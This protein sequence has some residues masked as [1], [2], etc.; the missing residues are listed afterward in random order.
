VFLPWTTGYLQGGK[1]GER[2]WRSVLLSILPVLL[3]TACAQQDT[4]SDSV[5]REA[6]RAALLRDGEAKQDFSVPP[7]PPI[8]APAPIVVAPEPP[9]P[10][11]TRRVSLA[12]TEDVPLRDVL[13]RLA[14]EAGIDLE[15]DPSITGGV[16]AIAHDRPF[17][18]VVDRLA[19]Q[20][21]LRYSMRNGVLRVERD[22]PYLK[23]YRVDYPNLVRKGVTSIRSSTDISTSVANASGTPGGGSNASKSEVSVETVSDYWDE[24]RA[25]IGAILASA[26]PAAGGG[27]PGPAT[28]AGTV[29]RRFTINRQAGLLTVF[30]TGREHAEIGHFLDRLR[31]SSSAQVLIE[32]KIVEVLLD[33]GYQ[34]GI[35][36]SLLADDLA[37][38]GQ[39]GTAFV[40][41]ATGFT[42]FALDTGDFD[43]AVTF[44]QEFGTARTLSSPRLLAL[45]NQQAVL[46][47]AENDVFFTVDVDLAVLGNVNNAQVVQSIDTEANTVPIGLIMTV[48]PSV[49]RASRDITLNLRPTV[50]RVVRR[51]QDPNPELAAA[52]VVSEIPVVE[53]R[54]V[55]TVVRMHSG[56]IVVMGGLMQERTI[57]NSQ[58]T[59]GLADIPLLGELFTGR[60]DQAQVSELVIFLKAT[61]VDGPTYHAQDQRVYDAF[62][63][64]PRPLQ[65]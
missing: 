7:P 20:A 6:Y 56:E 33:D 64:D 21:G 1:S 31:D 29:D 14:R 53:V 62:T 18:E 26:P 10:A 48:Q 45:N 44:V 46:K 5:A 65:F 59:P 58:R 35:D 17:I 38:S 27:E 40:L 60:D 39:L 43:A 42:R 37:I 57:N 19:A 15:L 30:A 8:P 2:R 49:D 41:D 55:D 51:V 28:E 23:T 25:S 63:E 34:T 12:V 52:N 9:S 3:I 36:W 22:T 54:E 13:F 47:V 32:A 16:I 11:D 4:A 61:I 50:T 24:V